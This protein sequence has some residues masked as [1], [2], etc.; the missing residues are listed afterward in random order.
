MYKQTKYEPLQCRWNWNQDQ[1]EFW[2]KQLISLSSLTTKGCGLRLECW[3]CGNSILDRNI[4]LDHTKC[5][6]N[7]WSISRNR[8]RRCGCFPQ[9]LTFLFTALV[10]RSCFLPSCPF[11]CRDM[12]DK[13][14]GLF[15][16]FLILTAA[17]VIGILQRIFHLLR[18]SWALAKLYQFKN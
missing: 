14:W 13:I 17:Q 6:K 15:P 16:K 2:Y 9:L 12:T 4:Q 8:S 5:F 7:C 18:F 10:C 11:S 3:S 1:S